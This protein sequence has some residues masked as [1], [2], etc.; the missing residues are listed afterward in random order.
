[1]TAQIEPKTWVQCVDAQGAGQ[2]LRRDGV[3]YVEALEPCWDRD[4]EA[5][6]FDC[7]VLSGIPEVGFNVKRFAPLGGNSSQIERKA[8]V[9]EPA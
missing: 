6:V 8:R 5:V 1:M 9:S 7:A 3:Y 2:Y 4:A